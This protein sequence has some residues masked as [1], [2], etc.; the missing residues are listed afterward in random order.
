MFLQQAVQWS[1]RYVKP[2]LS[3]KLP[4]AYRQ[5]LKDDEGFY[6]DESKNDNRGV[7]NC[8]NNN[9]IPIAVE[10]AVWPR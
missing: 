6:R 3:C 5:L 9:K 4:S 2:S 1:I 10:D 7:F 8:R